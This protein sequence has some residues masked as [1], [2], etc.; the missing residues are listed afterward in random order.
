MTTTLTYLSGCHQN[1]ILDWWGGHNMY[2]HAFSHTYQEQTDTILYNGKIWRVKNLADCPI[3]LWC[4]HWFN[5]LNGWRYSL[6]SI[7][8][9][10]LVTEGFGRPPSVNT[11]AASRKWPIHRTLMYRASGLTLHSADGHKWPHALVHLLCPLL[12]STTLAHWSFLSQ[13]LKQGHTGLKLNW[14]LRYNKITC[15][16]YTCI[17]VRCTNH[18]ART[19]IGRGFNLVDFPKKSPNLQ[20][21]KPA[22]FSRYTVSMYVINSYKISMLTSFRFRFCFRFSFRFSSLQ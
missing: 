17:Y 8:Q 12:E 22:K 3:E 11:S 2:I 10:C 4:N 9:L 18:T 1:D 5:C 13:V 16:P 6:H 14:N 15:S 7:Q 19:N 21:K 20:I